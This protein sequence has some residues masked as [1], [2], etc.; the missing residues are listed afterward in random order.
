[1]SEWESKHREERERMDGISKG[2]E[3]GERESEVD[4]QTD[5]RTDPYK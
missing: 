2:R 1:M 3:K 4:E 5:R